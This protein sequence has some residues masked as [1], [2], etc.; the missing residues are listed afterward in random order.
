MDKAINKEE[1]LEN[2]IIFWISIGVAIS[3][4]TATTMKSN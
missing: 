1:E 4:S 3:A 2:P